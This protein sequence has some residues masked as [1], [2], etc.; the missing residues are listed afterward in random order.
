MK[1][2]NTVPNSKKC[3]CGDCPSYLG[4]NEGFFCSAGKSKQNYEKKGCICG[5][6]DL[7]KEYKLGG[8]YFCVNGMSV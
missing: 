7:W 6:C 8:G 2:P 5:K 4:D 3:I 1:V